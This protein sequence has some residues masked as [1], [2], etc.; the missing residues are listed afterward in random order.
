MTDARSPK[1]SKA[2]FKDLEHKA[3]HYSVRTKKIINK[4]DDY[5]GIVML[6]HGVEFEAALEILKTCDK[7]SNSTSYSANEFNATANSTKAREKSFAD[8]PNQRLFQALLATELDRVKRTRLPCALMLIE[9]DDLAAA[10]TGEKPLGE[11]VLQRTASIIKD[12]LHM[13]DIFAR[14]GE[15]GFS[16][17]LPATNVGKSIASAEQLRNFIKQEQLLGDDKQSLQK[18]SI[19]I[20][21]CHAYDSFNPNNFFKL[22]ELRIL[23][24]S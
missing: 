19:G 21:V 2:F 14:Y 4:Q 5:L 23:R 13:V 12:A 10:D 1:G 15:Q 7:S 9:L 8:L 11:R 6:R 24:I 22:A 18:V 3:Q 16:I 20:A 17:I